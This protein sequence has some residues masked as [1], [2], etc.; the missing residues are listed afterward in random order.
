[1]V[2]YRR[3]FVPGGTY[4]F[5]VT[6]ADRRSRALVQNIDA[7]RTAFRTTREKCPFVVDAI[8]VLP[9]HLHTVWTLP[10]EDMDFPARWWRIKR[11]FTNAVGAGLWAR[12]FWEHTVRDEADFARH[13]DYIHFN[14]VKHGHVGRVRDWPYSSFHR[15][16]R[17]GLLPTDWADAP[18]EGGRYFGEG[19]P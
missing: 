14:P 5:T 10:A 3:N 13:L 2:R 12:R 7:L 1:M 15:F 6:L 8:V 19:R 18:D 9:E 17:Q 11:L 4:F 16:V